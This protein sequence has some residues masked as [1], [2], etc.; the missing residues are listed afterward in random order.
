M[1]SAAIAMMRAAMPLK[2][3]PATKYGPKMVECH[4]GT[5]AIEKSND[6]IVCTDTATG[7]MAIAM[8]CMAVSSRCHCLVV[9]RQP[10]ASAP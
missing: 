3:A 9:P 8:I 5:I 4:I 10:S 7:M 6:T 1:R 2:M